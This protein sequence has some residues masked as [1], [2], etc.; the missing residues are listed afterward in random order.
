MQTCAHHDHS[1]CN[2]GNEKANSQC[3]KKEIM[4]ALAGAGDPAVQQLK[5]SKSETKTGIDNLKAQM[6]R[7]IADRLRL[8]AEVEPQ[9]KEKFERTNALLNEVTATGTA[10]KQELRKLE[11]A[12]CNARNN[13]NKVINEITDCEHRA[14]YIRSIII[15]L[16]EKYANI[17]Y[18]LR[19]LTDELTEEEKLENEELLADE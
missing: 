19:Y 8:T 10:T 13:Y 18:W 11:T 6:K 5:S 7:E 2:H 1:T 17:D 12:V 4:V 16:E 15:N 14:N 3:D 9:L